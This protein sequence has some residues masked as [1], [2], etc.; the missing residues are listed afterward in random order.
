MAK[1]RSGK[2]NDSH[3]H[4]GAVMFMPV[5][6]LKAG[7]IIRSVGFRPPFMKMAAAAPSDKGRLFVNKHDVNPRL[8]HRNGIATPWAVFSGVD[9][10][11]A[12]RE[13]P[14]FM[15]RDAYW[16]IHGEHTGRQIGK[17]LED[18]VIVLD[19]SAYDSPQ[20]ESTPNREPATVA[21]EPP[22]PVKPA[23]KR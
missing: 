10:G 5:T 8:G 7:Q 13:A 21:E 3:D 22:K 2:P 18:G 16:T 1:D 20:P 14:V 12:P 17:V 15:T 23:G 9:T 11:G 6:E 19:P 4:T